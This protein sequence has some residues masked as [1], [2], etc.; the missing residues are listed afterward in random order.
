MSETE[1]FEVKQYGVTI[2]HGGAKTLER[3][4][5]LDSGDLSRKGRAAQETVAACMVCVSGRPPNP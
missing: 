1:T 2:N 4:L 5:L 3:V